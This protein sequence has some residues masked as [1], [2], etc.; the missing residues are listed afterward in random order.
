MILTLNVGSSSIKAKLFNNDLSLEK[1][2]LKEQIKTEHKEAFDEILS[3]FDK[4]DIDIVVHRVVHGGEFYHNAT[5][6]DDNVK[7]NIEYLGTLAP[8]H[9]P[10]NLL[11]IDIAQNACS[12]SLHVA[13]FDTAFHYTLEQKAYMYAL[14]SRLY[15]DDHIRRYGFHGSSHGY[16]YEKSCELLHVKS[17]NIITC[18]LGNGSS[19]CAIEQGKSI[20][21]SMGFTPL[22][23][24]IMGTRSGDIDP[25][26]I[27][28]LQK[29]YPDTD[30]EELLNKQ[31]GLKG[32]AGS[33]D[34]RELLEQ[35]DE[36]S[37]LAV[38]MFCY[39][40]A[41]YIG[42]YFILFEKLDAI[43]FTGGI[44]ENSAKIRENITNIISKSLHVKIKEESNL[45][46]EIFISTKE[47]HIK[48][49]CI[50]TDEELFMAKSALK[51]KDAKL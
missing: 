18:H 40:I 24:L 34:M 42:S 39:R 20:D 16:V 45:S 51:L 46:N 11:G 49:M 13:I 32:I 3:A 1:S 36:L 37:N 10:L 7:K 30:V 15:Q 31:S 19:I 28:Y 8:L 9:N 29:K 23:G 17:A 26:I 4:D 35:S 21:T 41:K 27:F 2:F 33:S 22:E 5:I 6:I 14:P 50:K 44:G 48:L 43:V 38:D 25:A 47:S 12:N